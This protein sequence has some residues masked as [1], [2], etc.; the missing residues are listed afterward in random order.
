MNDVRPLKPKQLRPQAFMKPRTS[1]PSEPNLTPV[2]APFSLNAEPKLRRP[3]QLL[4]R[5]V[6]A[7]LLLLIALIAYG[8]YWYNDALQ[9]RS[10][11]VDR[12]RITIERGAHAEAIGKELEEKH[13]IKSGLAFQLYV[14]QTDQNNTLQAGNYSL[15]PTQSVPE[16]VKLLVEGKMDSYNITILPG[17]SLKEIK[18]KLL[19]D[20]FES[21]AIDAAFAKTYDHPLLKDKP[22]EVSLEGYIFPETYHITLETTVEQLLVTSFDEFYKRLQEKNLIQALEARG[23]NLHTG[24]TLASLVQLE[25]ATD[26]D[27]RQVAQVFEKRLQVGMSLGSDVSL[28]YAAQLLDKPVSLD[29]DSPYNTRKYRGLPPGA[30]ANFNIAALEAVANSAPG[31]YLYFVSGDNGVTHF[32]HTLEEQEQKIKQYCKTLCAM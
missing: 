18:E 31:D 23:Y 4:I 27:R 9:P 3:M 29:I 20:G 32:S 24:F 5:A 13:V 1:Q 28:I 25:V 30:V 19:K 8:V 6:V 26:A 15:S 17:K 22:A 16:I 21:A 10:S 11:A 2:P 12:V 7:L 14:Q